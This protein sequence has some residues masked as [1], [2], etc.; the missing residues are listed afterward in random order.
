MFLRSRA[1]KIHYATLETDRAACGKNIALG[2]WT[3]EITRVTC[4]TCMKLLVNLHPK[5]HV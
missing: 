4:K 5:A 1:T 3:S 2:G